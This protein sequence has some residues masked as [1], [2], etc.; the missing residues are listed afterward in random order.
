LQETN[1]AVSS[2]TETPQDIFN[3]QPQPP[4][5]RVGPRIY[6]DASLIPDQNLPANRNARIGVYLVS[7][8]LHHNF[9]VHIKASLLRVSFVFTAEVAALA[10]G[11]IIVKRLQIVEATI[12]E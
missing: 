11:G 3:V 7:S 10:F 12:F 5:F 2:P 9:N 4:L 6:T 1:A 8:G